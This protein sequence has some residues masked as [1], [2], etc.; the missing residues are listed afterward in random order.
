MRRKEGTA[1][2]DGTGDYEKE[3]ADAKKLA[4]AWVLR[5]GNTDEI[6]VLRKQTNIFDKLQ[7]AIMDQNSQRWLVRQLAALAKT[8]K[9]QYR[10]VRLFEGSDALAAQKDFSRTLRDPIVWEAIGAQAMT[11][12]RIFFRFRIFGRASS[13]VAKFAESCK[14]QPYSYLANRLSNVEGWAQRFRAEQDRLWLP[15]NN[16]YPNCLY[17]QL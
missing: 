10:M 5:P 15:P 17:K 1:A 12:E 6:M 2:Q 7:G 9:R 11:R 4:R 14:Q 3:M 13:V 16:S 8:G